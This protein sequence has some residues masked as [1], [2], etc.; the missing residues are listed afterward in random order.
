MSQPPQSN[1][2]VSSKQPTPHMLMA[3]GT[4]IQQFQRL[5]ITGQGGGMFGMGPRMNDILVES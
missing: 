5:T 1:K 3:N 2:F 4:N